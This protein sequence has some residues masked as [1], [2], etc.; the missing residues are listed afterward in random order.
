M[1]C[2]SFCYASEIVLVFL[3]QQWVGSIEIF[4]GLAPAGIAGTLN[5]VSAWAFLSSGRPE[6]HLRAQFIATLIVITAFAI[7]IRWGPLGIAYGFSVGYCIAIPL[8]IHLSYRCCNLQFSDLVSAAWGPAIAIIIGCCM[9]KLFDVFVLYSFSIASQLGLAVAGFLCSYVLSLR[10]L[11][12][13]ETLAD[14]GSVVFA[15]A[16][17]GQT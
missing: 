16:R 1:S 15:R 10:C 3:G 13:W 9:S 7:G 14:T 8:V 17:S 4:R 5:G 11:P 12:H 6:L 2:F